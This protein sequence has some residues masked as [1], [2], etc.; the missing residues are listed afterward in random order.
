VIGL[1]SVQRVVL[2]DDG[3]CLHS[4]GQ[5]GRCFPMAVLPAQGYGGKLGKSAQGGMRPAGIMLRRPGV[6]VKR[7]HHARGDR[8]NM[9]EYRVP[10]NSFRES[11]LA[12]PQL[13]ADGHKGGGSNWG[14]CAVGVMA[15]RLPRW[16]NASVLSLGSRSQALRMALFGMQPPLR[17][18]LCADGGRPIGVGWPGLARQDVLPGRLDLGGRASPISRASAISV[19]RNIG[20]S[21]GCSAL[22]A[23]GWA[24][25]QGV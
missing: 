8:G 10:W 1:V 2:A 22:P 21:C 18:G 16:R 15:E 17:S 7:Q 5:V 25:R 6:N 24:C 12:A 23:P 13:R 11:S 9:R 4:D 19:D 20:M 14:G 3:E